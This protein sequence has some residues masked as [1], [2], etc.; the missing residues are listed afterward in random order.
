MFHRSIFL[1]LLLCVFSLDGQKGQKFVDSLKSA[2]KLA[3]HDT[4]R[5]NIL[6]FLSEEAPGDEW[7]SYSKQLM[8]I[9]KQ[10][11]DQK[12]EPAVLYQKYLGYALNFEGEIFNEKGDFE[13]AYVSYMKSLEIHQKIGSRS[14]IAKI[15]QYLAT[16]YFVKGDPRTALQYDLRSLKIYEALHDAYNILHAL[17]NTGAAYKSLSKFDSAIVCYQKGYELSRNVGDKNMMAIN[18]NNLAI[19]QSDLGDKKAALKNLDLSL[20]LMKETGNKAGLANYYVNAGSYY[21]NEGNITKALSFYSKALQI[22][23]EE[24]N[25]NLLAACYSNFAGIYKNMGIIK[26]S[27]EFDFKCLEIW[28]KMGYKHGIAIAFNNIGGIHKQMGD[29]EGA[30]KYYEKSLNID[31][32]IGN[33]VGVS[34]SMNN[35]GLIYKET[36][37]LK[38]A[39]EYLLRGIRLLE[40]A[41]EENQSVS[42]LNNLGSVY[43]VE[44]NFDEALKYHLKALD[45]ERAEGEK[46]KLSHTLTNISIVYFHKNDLNKAEKYAKESLQTARELHFL[47]D[48]GSAADALKHIYKQK[49]DFKNA[50]AMNELEVAMRDSVYSESNRKAS[51][52]QQLKY[53]YDKQA[54]ADSVSHAKESE[55]KSVELKKQAAEIKSKKNQQYVLFGGLGLVIMFSIF[56]FNRFRVTQKQKNIIESQKEMVEEQKKLVE[57]KQREVLESIHYAKK[58]QLAQIPSEKMVWS[59][60]TKTK[61]K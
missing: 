2:L 16:Y 37:N 38:E 1:V 13:K 49:N 34:A 52:K 50:L 15:C 6:I 3:T 20:E 48:I 9:A 33:K 47:S 32:K 53:E 29:R 55:I 60:I 58:I 36:G 8:Q 45:F 14:G 22:G 35:I 43:T 51:I 57:G 7:I 54:A 11:V 59:M 44:R 25:Q 56:M 30:L 40:E 31:E 5:C 61:R 4:T 42:L 26:K 46:M 10:N 28:T 17:R 19:I 24:N 23:K 27:L 18:L 39:K 12:N 41:G 21:E